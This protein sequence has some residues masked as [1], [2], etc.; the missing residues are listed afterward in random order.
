MKQTYLVLYVTSII[1][2][3]NALLAIDNQL[4]ALEMNAIFAIKSTVILLGATFFALSKDILNYLSQRSLVTK[5]IF[6]DS[7]KVIAIITAIVS[8]SHLE[9]FV[10]VIMFALC[11]PF[12]ADIQSLLIKNHNTQA[13]R[14]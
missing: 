4:T 2:S 9:S 5:S 11:I 10:V 7:L 14:G 3:L 13:P 6:S 1:L 8:Y 12:L